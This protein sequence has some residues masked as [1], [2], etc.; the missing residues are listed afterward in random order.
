MWDSALARALKK[1]ISATGHATDTSSSEKRASAL[2]YE[3]RGGTP[4]DS[5]EGQSDILET[6]V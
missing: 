6:G 1:R 3:L 2:A 4:A 5:H